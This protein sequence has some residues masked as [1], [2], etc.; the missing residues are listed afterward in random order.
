MLSGYSLGKADILRRAMG[1]KIE[2]EMIAQ[3]GEFVSG[4]ADNNIDEGLAGIFD[5]ISAFAVMDL[6]NPMPPPMR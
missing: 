6:I 5:Q 2:A 3:R 4:A 1:K